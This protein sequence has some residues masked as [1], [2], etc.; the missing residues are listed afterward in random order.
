MIPLRLAVITLQALERWHTGLVSFHR[1]CGRKQEGNG[2]A[3]VP[4]YK[5]ACNVLEIMKELC[6]KTND[7][8]EP[9]SKVETIKF[10]FINTCSV[11]EIRSCVCWFSHREREKERGGREGEREKERERERDEVFQHGAFVRDQQEW[12]WRIESRDSVI[13]IPTFLEALFTIFKRQKQPKCPSR[14]EWINKYGVYLQ[15]N[16]IQ[17]SKG[18]KGNSLAVQWLG[19]GTFTAEGPGSVPGMGGGDWDPTCYGYGQ[20]S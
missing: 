12:S 13:H 18:M 15:R 8:E 2:F 14:D 20:K 4:S 9:Q 5:W 3:E 1:G 19:L 17:P 11:R 7:L 16:I 6:W 10:R